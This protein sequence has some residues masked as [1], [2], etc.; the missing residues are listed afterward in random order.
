MKKTIGL[1][2]ALAF[3]A[4]FVQQ[5]L[6]QQARQ[7]WTTATEYTVVKGDSVPSIV[8][9][10]KYP[11]VTESQ[12]YFAVVQANLNDFSKN[13]VDRVLPGMKVKIPPEVE[14]AKVDVKRADS[15]M[16]SL[17]KAETIF[18][19]GVAAEKKGDMK[20]AV[21]KYITAAKT[22]HSYAQF[23]LGEL[24][25]RDGTATLPRDF[26]ESIKYYH[27]ARERGM[28]IKGPTPHIP[29]KG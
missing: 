29:A 6:A 9:K 26:Q 8:N 18:A 15:Y 1:L 13:T 19:E 28:E 20:T 24:Y 3:C 5:A 7:K 4:V 11:A 2:L 23:K 25:D 21:G 22:G 10:V 12:M 16:A 17:R 27:D 14:V